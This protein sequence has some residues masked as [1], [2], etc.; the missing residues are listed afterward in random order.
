MDY[1]EFLKKKENIGADYGKKPLFVP[2][3]MFDFQKHVLKYASKKGRAAV[4]LDTGLGKTVIELAIAQNYLPVSVIKRP[5]MGF[6]IPRER[7]LKGV[8]KDKV[9]DAILSGDS[10]MYS[11]LNQ[12]E[13]KVIYQNFLNGQKLDGVIWNLL[14]METWARN[15]IK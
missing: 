10:R 13:T 5:K 14:A 6:G 12:N 4:F 3:K 9:D 15:W 2:E 1:Q 7:W 11:W 8:L